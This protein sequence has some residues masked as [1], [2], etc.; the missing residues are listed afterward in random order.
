M[1]KKRLYAFVVASEADARLWRISIPYPVLFAIGFLAIIGIFTTGIATYKY[2]KMALKVRD[3][4]RLLT[5][6]DDFRS[7]NHNYRIQ[8]AQLGEKID[9]LETTSQKLMRVTGINDAGVGGYS[10]E[11]IS[12]P[13]SASAG[14]I[15]SIDAYNKNLTGLEQKYQTIEDR[16][17]DQS[18]V[19]ANDPNMLPVNGYVAGGWGLREDPFTGAKTEHHYGIDI[20]A[21]YGAKVVAPADATVI[22][23]GSRVGYGNI[24]VLDHRF[25]K[26]TRYGHLSRISVQIGQRVSRGDVVGYVG[27]SGRTTGPHLHFEIWQYGKPLNPQKYLAKNGQGVR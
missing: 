16:L 5:Q 14:T 7:E 8:T 3:Y 25:G 27:S 22:F 10:R 15:R 12:R 2:G 17:S 18:L 6:N 9:Y 19:K 4:N 24:V 21:P 23:A 13:A 20:S 1:L 26:T 11:S